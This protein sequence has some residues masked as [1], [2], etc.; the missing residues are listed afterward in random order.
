MLGAC[1][2]RVQRSLTLLGRLQAHLE[3]QGCDDSARQAAADVL[4]YFDVAAPLHHEDEE[5]HV[6][7][8]LLAQGSA[9][10]QA[11]VRELQ[12]DHRLMESHWANA[13]KVLQTVVNGSAETWVAQTPEQTAALHGFTA[14]YTDHIEREEQ[15]VYPAAQIY[16]V[17]QALQAMRVDMMRRR[18]QAVA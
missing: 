6:F 1:H 8:P 12:Q 2:E 14:L 15:V 10:I 5:L 17:P 9:E 18:G 7:P 13:R 4:R 11:L 3:T 16:M